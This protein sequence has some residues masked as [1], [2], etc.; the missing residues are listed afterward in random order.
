[1]W[2]G[3]MLP[4]VIVLTCE[5]LAGAEVGGDLVRGGLGPWGCMSGLG[6]PPRDPEQQIKFSFIVLQRT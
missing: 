5:G 4:G 3:S 1:M 6:N 2:N